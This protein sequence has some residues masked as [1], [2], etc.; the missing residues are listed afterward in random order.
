MSWSLTASGSAAGTGSTN[1]VAVSGL[2]T[3]SSNIIWGLLSFYNANPSASDLADTQSN[4][5]TLITPQAS[6]ADSNARVGIFYKIA[7]SNSGSL[8]VTFT[9]PGGATA[10]FPSLIVFAHT[11]G[12]A[13]TFNTSIGSG[14]NS[15]GSVQAGSIGNANDLVIEAMAFYG[16]GVSGNTIDGSFS[17]VTEVAYG[18]GTNIGLA[19]AWKEVSVA[20]NPTWT[21]NIANVVAAQAAAVTGT[22]GGATTWGPLLGMHTNRLVVT[23]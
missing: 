7:P 5:Y 13:P 3:G 17:A 21:V 11:Q 12:S 14:T 8:T 23:Q 2:N 20:V 19:A 1:P 10:Q 9:P 22:G 18:A 16:A 4:S 15:S 6:G